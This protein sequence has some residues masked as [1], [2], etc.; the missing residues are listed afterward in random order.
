MSAYTSCLDSARDWKRR[1]GDAQDLESV[2]HGDQGIGGSELVGS[3]K[4]VLVPDENMIVND[5]RL[6]LSLFVCDQAHMSFIL[7]NLSSSDLLPRAL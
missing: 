6:H 3:V 5:D 4:A 7:P 2:G 1:V